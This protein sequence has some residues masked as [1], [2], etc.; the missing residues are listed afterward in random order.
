MYYAFKWEA[1]RLTLE[2]RKSSIELVVSSAELHRNWLPPPRDGTKGHPQRSWKRRFCTFP[3][4]LWRWTYVKTSILHFFRGALTLNLC[5]TACKVKLWRWTY[6]KLR[7]KAMELLR[8]FAFPV[9]PLFKNKLRGIWLDP[10]WAAQLSVEATRFFY[11]C[12][13]K[14]EA[15]RKKYRIPQ[16]L[17]GF[18]HFKDKASQK[19]C[20]SMCFYKSS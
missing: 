17:R 9:E 6:V 10:V 20:K 4:E 1:P 18:L 3:V 11:T 5:Q 12:C 19:S 8:Y 13:F 2:S 15:P 16:K 14:S 7:A